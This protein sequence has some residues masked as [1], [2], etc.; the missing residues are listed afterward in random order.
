MKLLAKNKKAYHEYDIIQKFVAGIV[1]TGAEVKSVLNGQANLRDSFVKVVNEEAFAWNV[2]IS[3]YKYAD[4]NN[5]DP[6]RTRKLLLHKKEIHKIMGAIEQQGLTV[7]PLSMFIQNKKIKLEI[8]IVRG[9]KKFDKREKEKKRDIKRKI[10]R[11]KRNIV[12]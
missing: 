5:Y 6:Y 12:V 1:L 10:D 9:L 11:A 7:V 8:A 3:C 2:S 4:C